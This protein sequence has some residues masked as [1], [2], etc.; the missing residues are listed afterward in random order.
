M[1]TGSI[2]FGRFE[3]ETLSWERRSSFSHNRYL[4]EVVKCATPGSVTQ[5]RAILEAHFKKKPLLPQVSLENQSAAECQATEND[6]DHH[7]SCSDEFEDR[8]DGRQPEFAWYDETPTGSDGHEVVECEQQGTWSSEYPIESTPCNDK[9]VVDSTYEQ[10]DHDEIL[11]HQPEN[12]SKASN[13]D[14]LCVVSEQEPDNKAVIIEE[15]LGN[16]ETFI[17]EELPEKKE[18]TIVEELMSVSPKSA[19]VEKERVPTLKKKTQKAPV[20]VRDCQVHC[21]LFRLI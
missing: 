12:N 4:E 17:V 5:K 2:S 3:L 11:Q 13:K 21:S 7:A 10:S 9:R 20:K 8:D 18:A 15:I 14:D 6:L 19:A 16:K 1:P